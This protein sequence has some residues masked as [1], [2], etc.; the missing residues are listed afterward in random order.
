MFKDSCD[1]FQVRYR[2][3][4]PNQVSV[5]RIDEL[6][7]WR[8]APNYFSGRKRRA[9]AAS[10]PQFDGFYENKLGLLLAEHEKA[11]YELKYESRL[12]FG[13]GS[14]PSETALW[15]ATKKILMN[16]L[17]QLRLPGPSTPRP[18]PK[19]PVDPR[20]NPRYIPERCG[21]YYC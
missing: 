1:D 3:C 9:F 13:T 2:C 15:E 12:E 19:L 10:L 8:S 14:I 6:R 4:S 20:P 7:P 21:N 17:P 18:V 16:G 5:G 11:V